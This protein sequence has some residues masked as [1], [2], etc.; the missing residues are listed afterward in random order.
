MREGSIPAPQQT[1]LG[2]TAAQ[3]EQLERVCAPNGKPIRL[4]DLRSVEPLGGVAEIFEG[5]I[6]REH[7]ALGTY[8]GDR[9]DERRRAEMPRCREMEIAPEIV[10][11][12]LAGGIFVRGFHP[13]VPV[14]DAPDEKRQAFAE[15]TENDLQ[16]RV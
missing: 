9:V 2:L 14:V 10:H 11:H 1:S 13:V 16:A 7:D 5:I 6:D 8:L 12:A 15:M 4:A 3:L